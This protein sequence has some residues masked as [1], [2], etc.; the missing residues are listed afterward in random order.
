MFCPKTE[1]GKQENLAVSRWGRGRAEKV[2]EGPH[3]TYHPPPPPPGIE[4][5]PQLLQ[6]TAA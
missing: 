3:V 5:K 2:K 6:P 1:L 4:V